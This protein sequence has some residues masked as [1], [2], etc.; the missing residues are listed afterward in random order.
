MYWA[1]PAWLGLLILTPLP[2]LW[3]R[4]RPRLS[5]PTL[6]PFV[7]TRRGWAVWASGLPTLS[8]SVA[9]AAMAV[10]LA[11]PQTIGGRT[12]VAGQGVA[13]VVAIDRSSSMKAADF[14]DGGADKPTR[15]D[16]AKRT[17][18]RFIQGRLDDPIGVVAFANY[19]DLTCPP[20]LDHEFARATVGAL[21]PAVGSD[22]GTNLGDALAVGLDALRHASA[23]SRVLVLVSDGRND[24]NVA[25]P[26]DPREAARIARGLGIVVHT[27]AVGDAGGL[28]RSTDAASNLPV[29]SEVGGP[30]LALL[31]EI[32]R[33]GGGRSFRATD[34][35][36]LDAIFAAIDELEKSP[37]S[38]TI[39]TRYRERFAPW[40]VVALVCLTVQRL[41]RDGRLS[42]LP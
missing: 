18:D 21:S 35:R 15:L 33:L 32:A 19:P 37:V 39:L 2:W 7:G 4:T 40:A 14:A 24:P 20:T 34:A 5:W 28:V 9:I 6:A 8:L 17:L 38:G 10:A 42:R 3:E 41:M 30:D 16:A 23:R 13:I 27:I 31:A 12:R 1:E 25:R 26:L 29:V 22:D 36:S 11:R